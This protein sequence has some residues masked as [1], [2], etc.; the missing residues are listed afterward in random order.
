MKRK[1]ALE[2]QAAWGDGPC[3]HP[4]F[5]KEYDNGV[6]TGNFACMQC[7]AVLGFR[8]KGQLMAERR[9]ADSAGDE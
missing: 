8:E 1:R 7:G 4:D 3:S 2:L 6:K 5:A 9:A